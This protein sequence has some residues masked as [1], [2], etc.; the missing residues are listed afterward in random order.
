M[1][2]RWIKKDFNQ[3]LSS[4]EE[5][6]VNLIEKEADVSIVFWRAP[7]HAGWRVSRLSD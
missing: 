6:L 7:K 3:I 4:A 1:L 2:F 5:N